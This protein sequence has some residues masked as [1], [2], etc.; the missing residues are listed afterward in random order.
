MNKLTT[1]ICKNPLCPIGEQP[2]S[3]FHRRGNKTQNICKTC[4]NESA[5]SDYAENGKARKTQPQT[6]INTNNFPALSER[7]VALESKLHAKARAFAHDNLDADDIYS[8][9]V[10][11]IL[12][13]CKPEDKDAF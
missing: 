12:T 4:R 9:M 2:I 11:A 3:N 10:E 6:Q 5:R 13:K 1:Q 8:E 7:I